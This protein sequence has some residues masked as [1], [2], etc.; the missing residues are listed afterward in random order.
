MYADF[1]I[2]ESKAL[3]DVLR[4]P[5]NCVAKYLRNANG[6][7]IERNRARREIKGKIM[8]SRVNCFI[9]IPLCALTRPARK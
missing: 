7:D 5:A 6:I 9:L 4:S 3:T 1:D 8:L 2:E